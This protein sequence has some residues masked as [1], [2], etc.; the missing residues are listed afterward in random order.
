MQAQKGLTIKLVTVEDLLLEVPDLS[1][2]GTLIPPD[3]PLPVARA[4]DARP[5]PADL[6]E[7]VKGKSA[8]AQAIKGEEGK[9]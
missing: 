8:W 7:S 3:L 4:A 1:E 6:V 2:P 9:D 5:S